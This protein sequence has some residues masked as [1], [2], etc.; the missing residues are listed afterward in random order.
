M[1]VKS[2]MF[3]EEL[4]FDDCLQLLDSLTVWE[5]SQKLAK[6]YLEND[7]PPVNTVERF[8]ALQKLMDAVQR[9]K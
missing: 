1:K 5:T 3:K 6:R 2:A 8:E 4:G 7:L 9:E